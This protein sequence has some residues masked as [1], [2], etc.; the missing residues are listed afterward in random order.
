M[1]LSL[2]HLQSFALE[3]WL[4]FMNWEYIMQPVSQELYWLGSLNPLENV[5]VEV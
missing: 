4:V 3:I 5:R 2:S 1:L